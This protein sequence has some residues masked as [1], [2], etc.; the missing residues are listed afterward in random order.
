VYVSLFIGIFCT[1]SISLFL[2]VW[3]VD[4]SNISVD[5]LRHDFQTVYILTTDQWSRNP[6]L[7]TAVELRWL[8]AFSNLTLL[9][10]LFPQERTSQIHGWLASV[11]MYTRTRSVIFPILN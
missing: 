3:I 5:L 7:R 9:I 1:G 8:W 2:L 11:E 6:H 10:G 4:R